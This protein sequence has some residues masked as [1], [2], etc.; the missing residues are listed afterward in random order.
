MLSYGRGYNINFTCSIKS[1]AVTENIYQAQN[2][3]LIKLN[4]SNIIYLYSNDPA[5]LEFIS[6]ICGNTKTADGS[7]EPLITPEF[8][9]VVNPFE[10][11]VIK[12]RYMPMKTKLIPAYE[13][14]WGFESENTDL[15]ERK[16]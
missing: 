13:V 14:D 3:D 10:A 11:V 6:K 16:D 15:P 4:F 12:S 1:I 9:K 5:T 8:L 2:F 7:I